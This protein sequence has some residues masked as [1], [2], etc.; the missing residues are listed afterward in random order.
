MHALVNHLVDVASA[1]RRRCC[2]ERTVDMWKVG[3]GKAG[4]DEVVGRSI[5]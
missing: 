1:M 3:D 4:Y 2:R 5:V